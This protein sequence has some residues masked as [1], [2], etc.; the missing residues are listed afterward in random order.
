MQGNIEHTI[1][2][3]IVACFSIF[4]LSGVFMFFVYHTQQKLKEKQA[5][6][7]RAIIEAQE[8]E[9]QRIGRDLHDEVGPLLTLLKHSLDK[10]GDDSKESK[11][12][13]TKAIANVRSA[14]HNL[15]PPDINKV[16]LVVSLE[17]LCQNFNTQV[18]QEISFVGGLGN[19][20]LSSWCNIHVYRITAELITNA[21]KHS[22]A[23]N[24]VVRIKEQNHLFHL[25]VMDD[26]I[27]IEKTNADLTD[28]IGWQ[29][30]R[31]RLNLMKGEFDI[32]SEANNGTQVHIQIPF[33]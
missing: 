8:N 21:L 24:I 5:Q 33:S 22:K 23:D 6:M 3:A 19:Q 17:K 16:G 12:L 32:V 10:Y 9:Q 30:I 27:G 13:I 15:M 18:S 26:G 28:G 11:D 4:I 2:I 31:H 1:V 29:N 7:Y 20:V 25:S 14:A